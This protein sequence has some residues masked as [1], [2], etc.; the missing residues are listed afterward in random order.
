MENWEDLIKTLPSDETL[1]RL[2]KN[3]TLDEFDRKLK[4]LQEQIDRIKE[5]NV[6]ENDEIEKMFQDIDKNTK[7]EDNSRVLK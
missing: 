2:E 6:K 5:R 7:S 4:M 3:G 1:E